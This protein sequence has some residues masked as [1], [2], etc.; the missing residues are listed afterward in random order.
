MVAFSLLLSVHQQ[1]PLLSLE[2]ILK[3]SYKI[4]KHG[5]NIGAGGNSEEKVGGLHGGGK[6]SFY[7]PL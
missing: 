7:P 4:R 3:F 6:E 2:R 1:T 5:G